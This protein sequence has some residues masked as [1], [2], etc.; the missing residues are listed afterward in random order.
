VLRRVPTP[1]E[2]AIVHSGNG[3]GMNVFNALYEVDPD[4]RVS[5]GVY[6]IQIHADGFVQSRRIVFLK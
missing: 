4:K 1:N 2:K 5:A 3:F 6:F